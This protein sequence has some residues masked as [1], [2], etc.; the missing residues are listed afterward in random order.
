[1]DNRLLKILLALALSLPVLMAV[2][3][4]GAQQKTET[5]RVAVLTPLSG[6]GSQWGMCTLRSYELMAEKINREGGIKAN[7]KIYMVELVKADTKTN[8]TEALNQANRLVFEE[9]VQYIFG[10]IITSCTLAIQPVTEKNKVII[11]NQSYSPKVLGPDKPY[12]FR[13]YASGH[14]RIGAIYDFLNKRYPKVKTIGLIGPNDESAWGTSKV[15]KDKAPSYGLEVT[16]EDYVQ[17]G[18]NDFFPVLTKMVAKKPDALI[19][20]SATPGATALLLQQSYQL[21]YKGLLI[22]PS[23]Y[24][25]K[26]LVEKAGAEA[27]EGF[28]FQ[29]PDEDYPQNPPGVK[30][31]IDNYVAKYKETFNPITAATYPMLQVLKMAIEKAGT[32][33]TTAVVKAMES[34]E[35]DYAFGHFSMGGLKTY[36]INHQINEPIFMSM[37]TK[38][39]LKGLGSFTALAP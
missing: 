13:L 32:L 16:F 15:A 10:P 22:S 18:T 21:G 6:G 36:G 19:P 20:H 25:P 29:T 27:V 24:D 34:L 31:M 37:L 4:Q 26:M 14:E 39:K 23:H 8:A 33:E 12:T 28:I 2:Q 11:M 9:K 3:V 7:D 30:E 38:G 5:L 1:M 35:G 17:R